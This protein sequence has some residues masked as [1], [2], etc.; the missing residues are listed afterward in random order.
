MPQSWPWYKNLMQGFSRGDR[1]GPGEKAIPPHPT[2]PVSRER[3]GLVGSHTPLPSSK[4]V[5]RQSGG[6]VAKDSCKMGVGVPEREAL[7]W[8]CPGCRLPAASCESRRPE[9]SRGHRR[10]M[11]TRGWGWGGARGTVWV[12]GRAWI[13]LR[14]GR[15]S[16]RTQ[17][18]RGR[19]KLNDQQK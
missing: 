6:E 7:P 9:G 18:S 4:T 1:K 3:K 14:Q 13:P 10:S 16:P 19:Q 11:G 15:L 2:H 5:P 8:S 12:G 17:N